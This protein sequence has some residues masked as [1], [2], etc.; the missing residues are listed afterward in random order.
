MNVLVVCREDLEFKHAKRYM[1]RYDGVFELEFNIH[2]TANLIGSRWRYLGDRFLHGVLLIKP[3]FI[4]FL[5][6]A[7]RPILHTPIPSEVQKSV[8]SK[9]PQ[10][11]PAR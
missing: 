8:S 4:F 11:S 5:S 6:S 10:I 7:H 1:R 3:L 9:I 2:V